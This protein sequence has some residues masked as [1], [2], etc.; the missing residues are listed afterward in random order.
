MAKIVFVSNQE[1]MACVVLDKRHDEVSQRTHYC[2]KPI[3]PKEGPN[4]TVTDGELSSRGFRE[5]VWGPYNYEERMRELKKEWFET[6]KDIK[7]IPNAVL[8][9]LSENGKTINRLYDNDKVI[10]EWE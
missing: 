5:E 4:V 10:A 9:R 3:L 1:K 2:V 7:V 6:I 8:I